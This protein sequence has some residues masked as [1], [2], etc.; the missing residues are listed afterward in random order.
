MRHVHIVDDDAPYRNSVRSLLSVQS[1]LILRCFASG[2]AFLAQAAELDAGVL[3][4]DL[5]M[6][7]AGGME[8]L[9]AIGGD[10]S[11]H[12]VVVMTAEGD[13]SR[14][15]DAIKAG[16]LDFVEKPCAPERLLQTI[17]TAF[18][19]LEQGDA[20][21]Q[22]ARAA[23]AKITSLSPREGDV[24]KGLIEGRPNKVIAGDLDLSPRTVEIH[25]ANLM[26]KLSARS[27]SDALRVAFTA[28]LFAAE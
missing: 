27:L 6:P 22:R 11:R 24:L 26:E 10:D 7:G 2:D 19:R 3:L 14:A 5:H 21:A 8:V 4:L 17:E 20:V 15:V 25:R 9:G 1:N 16:A 13:V 18:A 28:G 12:A 23:K